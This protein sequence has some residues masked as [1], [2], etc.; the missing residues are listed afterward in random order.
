M[1]LHGFHRYIQ[2]IRDLP[3]FQ[4]FE[5]TQLKDGAALFRQFIQGFPELL[6]QFFR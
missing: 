3:I 4:F 5:T 1:V 2:F 6:F